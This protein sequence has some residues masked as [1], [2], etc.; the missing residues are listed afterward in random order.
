MVTDSTIVRGGI[1][2]QSYVY[3]TVSLSATTTTSGILVFIQNRNYL[4]PRPFGPVEAPLHH[5]IIGK[6]DGVQLEIEF[7]FRLAHETVKVLSPPGLDEA[8]EGEFG[9]A[10]ANR[11]SGVSVPSPHD[12][13]TS[14][15]T[16]RGSNPATQD[17]LDGVANPSGT[18]RYSRRYPSNKSVDIIRE[19]P[20]PLST[21]YWAN[22]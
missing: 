20:Y 14:T 7:C 19:Y 12:A 10:N 17:A 9:G 3:H 21:S 18:D 16:I 4:I 6:D 2:P 8:V 15:R 5:S 1:N 22:Q 13:P 11:A